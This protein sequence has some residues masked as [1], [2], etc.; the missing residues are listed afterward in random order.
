MPINH[1]LLALLVP[2]IWGLNFIFVKFSLDVI[3]PLYLCALRFLLASIPA[4]FFIR[5]PAAPFKIVVGYGLVMFALQFAFLF[6]GMYLGM[7]P[8]MASLIVQVQVFF[9]MFF[10]ALFLG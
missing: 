8:G 1:L 2:V 5:R 4:I 6:L 7:T 9:S 10:A 3:S